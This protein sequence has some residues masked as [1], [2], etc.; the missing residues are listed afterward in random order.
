MRALVLLLAIVSLIG[1][2]VAQE[3]TGKGLQLR[4]L[5][6]A[7]QRTVQDNQGGR[8]QEH[9]QRARGWV[10][11]YSAESLLNGKSRIS[12]WMPRATSCWWKRRPPST[13]FL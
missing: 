5:P 6:A 7:V 10:E 1:S 11:Q 3:K 12:T 2:A 8:D 9:R 13:P 4:D